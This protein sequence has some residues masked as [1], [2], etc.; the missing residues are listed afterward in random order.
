[1]LLLSTVCV[2]VLHSWRT[3]ALCLHAGCNIGTWKK[4]ESAGV[5]Y[6]R[7]LSCALFDNFRDCHL[8]TS[9][10][11]RCCILTQLD[12]RRLARRL[13]QTFQVRSLLRV[14]GSDLLRIMYRRAGGR[15]TICI[16]SVTVASCQSRASEGLRLLKLLCFRA[17]TEA[18]RE[19]K[20]NQGARSQLCWRTKACGR[21]SFAL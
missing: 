4:E 13:P 10:I 15:N 18:N 3:A 9:A 20:G 2:W 12:T 7:E 8:S 11:F 21:S 5:L 17:G 16:L 6:V 1:M 14:V 19:S